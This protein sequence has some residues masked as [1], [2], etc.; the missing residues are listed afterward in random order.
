MASLRSGWVTSDGL[1]P[2]N[3]SQKLNTISN[4]PIGE[5]NHQ[6]L[7][8]FVKAGKMMK[9]KVQTAQNAD[10]TMPNAANALGI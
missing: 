6:R 3:R 7:T 1:N 8:T 9:T 2:L 10:E 4:T 5:S